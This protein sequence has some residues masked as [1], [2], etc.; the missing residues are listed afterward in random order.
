MFSQ[1]FPNISLQ[2]IVK[3]LLKS[4][5]VMVENFKAGTLEKYGLSFLAENGCSLQEICKTM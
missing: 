2:E 1:H 3:R 4:S 5:D